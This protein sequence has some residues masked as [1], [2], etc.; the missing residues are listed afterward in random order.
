MA[1]KSRSTMKVVLLEDIYKVG[2]AGEIVEVRPGYARNYLVPQGKAMFATPEVVN[3]LERIRQIAEEKRRAKME[4][5]GQIFADIKGK[6]VV[7]PAK[8]GPEGKLFGSV[9][10]RDIA[11]QIKKQL[12]YPE[13]DFHW[14][15]LEENIRYIGSYPVELG[16][17]EGLSS[18]IQVEVVSEEEYSRRLA[19]PVE[20]ESVIAPLEEEPAAESQKPDSG[21]EVEESNTFL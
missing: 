8:V 16:Y 12:G 15:K 10:A 20:D 18:S 5:V 7:I 6:T 14:I 17:R 2:E 4:E 21:S 19:A 13:F 1:R 3:R 11:Q 9:T